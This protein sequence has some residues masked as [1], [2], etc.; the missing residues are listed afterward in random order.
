MGTTHPKIDVE[1]WIYTWS[2]G[3][4]LDVECVWAGCLEQEGTNSLKLGWVGVY[5]FSM[6][7]CEVG[8][9]WKGWK[10]DRNTVLCWE[11]NLAWIKSSFPGSCS[12]RC[13]LPG[14]GIF[15]QIFLQVKSLQNGIK[16]GIFSLPNVKVLEVWG[17]LAGNRR[18]L[19]F[20]DSRGGLPYICPSPK[21]LLDPLLHW[22]MTAC[23]ILSPLLSNLPPTGLQSSLKWFY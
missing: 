6:C 14:N 7:E 8:A 11:C 1:L 16:W 21:P 12:M 3:V 2:E 13:R 10:T 9:V 22:I 23:K 15:F 20:G 5:M 4:S 18:K 17:R 19:S